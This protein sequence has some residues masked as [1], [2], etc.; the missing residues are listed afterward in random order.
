VREI[1]KSG[2]Q[3][4]AGVKGRSGGPRKNAGGK[5]P[6]A[7]RKPK[8]K[9]KAKQAPRAPLPELSAAQDAAIGASLPR[10]PA[11]PPEPEV[12]GEGVGITDAKAFLEGV[13]AGRIVADESRLKA[14]QYLLPFQHRKLGEGGKKEHEKEQAGKVAS[15]FAPA[16]PRLAAIGGKSVN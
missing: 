16:P 4:M 1:S 6:G 12:A 13:M 7:G 5:R 15:R 3:Q 8:P 14:A 11:A 10:G 9:A 2:N